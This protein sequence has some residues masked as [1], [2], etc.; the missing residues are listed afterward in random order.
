MMIERLIIALVLLIIGFMA[1]R[2]LIAAQK[3]RTTK[4]AAV[5]PLVKEALG[6]PTIV[7]FT[8]PTCI[9]CR[10]TQMPA[11]ERVHAAWGNDLRVVQIDAT[12]EPEAASRWGVFS[13]PTT[14]ILNR[15][16]QT[17]AVNH[18]VADADLL[19]RQLKIAV[20]A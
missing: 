3:R 20:G 17:V 6:A 8:T 2:L 5:D 15:Q 11:I 12:Q 18:G 10:T 7:Y 9:P 13:A 1:Y 19:Q 16:G 4:V 14:F